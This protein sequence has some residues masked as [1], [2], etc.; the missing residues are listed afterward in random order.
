MGVP[1]MYLGGHHIYRHHRALTSWYFRHRLQLEKTGMRMAWSTSLPHCTT[2]DAPVA[3][4]FAVATNGLATTAARNISHCMF[5]KRLGRFVMETT[6]NML[7]RTLNQILEL[8]IS[9]VSLFL[10]LPLNAF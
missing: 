6:L 8:T 1:G 7:I 10:L 9:V 2:T 5:C 4:V 3:S